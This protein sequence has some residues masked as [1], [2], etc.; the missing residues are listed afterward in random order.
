MFL[1]NKQKIGLNKFTSKIQS[2]SMASELVGGAGGSPSPSPS[3]SAAAAVLADSGG[4]R[5]GPS[6]SKS[7][8]YTCNSLSGKVLNFIPFPTIPIETF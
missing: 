6:P 7:V 1:Y 5:R 4:G 8:K 2:V 3:P